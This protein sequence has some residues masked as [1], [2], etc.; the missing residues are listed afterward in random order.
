MLLFISAMISRGDLRALSAASE[1]LGAGSTLKL[2]SDR[3][4]GHQVTKFDSQILKDCSFP[5]V[6][7]R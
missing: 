6:Y 3:N 1:A 5:N 4:G 7:R 2:D